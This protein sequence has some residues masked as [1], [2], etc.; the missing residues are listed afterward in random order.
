MLQMYYLYWPLLINSSE[1]LE[2]RVA[3]LTVLMLSRPT[4][5]HFYNLMLFMLQEHNPHLRH[6]WYTTLHSLVKTHYPCYRHM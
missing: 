3:A 6:F 1:D 2:V 5:S 4:L